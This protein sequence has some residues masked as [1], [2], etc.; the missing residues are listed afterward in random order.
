MIIGGIRM[1]CE[2]KI[3]EYCRQ[4]VT[5]RKYAD[6]RRCNNCCIECEEP[7]SNIC[8]KALDINQKRI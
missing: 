1:K 3:G 4:A 5:Y 2:E 7:C 8:E 6:I